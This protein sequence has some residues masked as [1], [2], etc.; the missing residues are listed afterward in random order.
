MSTTVDLARIKRDVRELVLAVR[1]DRHHH[2][3]LRVYDALEAAERLLK[4]LN[5][6]DESPVK[7]SLVPDACETAMGA[8][9]G[10][11]DAALGKKYEGESD[12]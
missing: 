4:D 3:S 6:P 8:A 5:I 7:T 2:Y 12:E 10:M 11:V 9:L 1:A